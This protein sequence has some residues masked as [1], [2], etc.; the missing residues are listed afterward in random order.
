[1]KTVGSLYLLMIVS[2]VCCSTVFAADFPAQQPVRLEGTL[3]C[4][5]ADAT[6]GA[7]ANIVNDYGINEDGFHPFEHWDGE[8]GGAGM[9]VSCAGGGGNAANNPAGLE[10][11]TWLKIDFD[12]TY[13]LGTMWVWNHNQWR[14]NLDE[15]N[16]GLKNV[17]IHYSNDGQTWTK[18]GNYVFPQA[19]GAEWI[20]HNY[21]V[22]FGGV[23]ANSVLVTAAAIDGNYGSNYY[24]LSELMF[25]IEGKTYDPYSKHP[26]EASIDSDG[27]T[28]S[29]SSTWPDFT[30]AYTINGKP[31]ETNFRQTAGW[32]HTSGSTVLS[33]A[34]PNETALGAA[35][36]R[37][38]F[39]QPYAMGQMWIWNHNQPG[40]TGRGLRKVYIEYNDGTQW[41]RVM[42]GTED[43]F[44]L[45]QASGKAL[46]EHTDA[47]DFDG[48]TATS[49]VITADPNGGM[50]G[51]PAADPYYGLNEV[52]F[53]I[54]NTAWTAPGEPEIVLPTEDAIHDTRIVATASSMYEGNNSPQ[55]TVNGKGLN[56]ETLLH[57]NHSHAW[58]MWHADGNT[59][60]DSAH[61]N[62]TIGYE[63]IRFVFDKTYPLGT[64]WVWNQNQS[65]LTN[66]GFKKVYIEY[67]T[68]GQNWST[69]MDGANDYFIFDQASGENYI[70]HTTAVDFAGVDANS[71]VITADAIDGH[72]GG[73]PYLGLSEVRFGIC[74]TC[75]RGHP[76][77]VDGDLDDDFDVDID[78][79]GVFSG[80]WLD[81]NT[82]SSEV[83]MV[84]DDF[85]IYNP[86]ADPNLLTL[87]TL[88]NDPDVN[89]EIALLTNPEDA[90]A[91]SQAMRWTWQEVTDGTYAQL[92]CD[93]NG[94][95]M[96]EYDRFTLWIYRH[97]YK[98]QSFVIAPLDEQGQAVAATTIT[99]FPDSTTSP[100]GQWSQIVIDLSTIDASTPIKQ[101][102]FDITTDYTTD[103]GTLDIDDIEFF[104]APECSVELM[105]DLNGNC[106]VNLD[107]FAIMASHWLAGS[108]Y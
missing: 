74:G 48:V 37:Y 17:Q 56:W 55:N 1:M 39:D 103:S 81:D 45:N 68:D 29:A 26:Q 15:T 84:I 12:K 93:A 83:T 47:I 79:M 50:W 36:L 94:I 57:D 90:Y 54:A 91:G 40:L 33:S 71:V 77:P 51:N 105:A 16:R 2:L 22:D 21:E 97:D 10:C 100:V 107:D 13:S 86:V 32:W 9:W 106:R 41:N 6:Y 8:N 4:T 25:G 23:D 72:W 104:K 59:D 64:M 108:V 102:R 89:S 76:V 65:G 101:I 99:L 66:R 20:A 78:D 28:A 19:V 61:P 5:A 60:L 62:T 98:H 82:A 70:Q 58:T 85:E 38:D 53:G 27:I 80:L 18:L 30:P 42:N 3:S 63:W 52:L 92:V 7:A 88:L 73:A 14:P 67:T 34:E 96:N 46:I 31:L 69:L 95:D 35:W 11:S 44:I 87:W 24:G 49:V 43:Y 75:Y